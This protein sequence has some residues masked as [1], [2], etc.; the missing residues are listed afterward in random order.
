MAK[1]QKDKKYI[2]SLE[3]QEI[4]KGYGR[5]I[6]LPTLFKWLRKNGLG[7]QFVKGSRWYIDKEKFIRFLETGKAGT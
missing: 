4:L 6:S 5:A 1:K 7:V 2:D 3:A